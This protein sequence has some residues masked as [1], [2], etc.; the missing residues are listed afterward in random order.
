MPLVL[1]NAVLCDIDPPRVE[2][3]NLRIDG[4]KIVARGNVK[5]SAGDEVIDCGG[6]VLLPGLVNGHTHLYSA[7]AVGMPAPPRAPKNFLEILQ[8]VWWRLDRALDAEGIETSALIGALEAVRCGT[9]TLIDHHASPNCIDGSL[10]LIE[11]GLEKVGL[12]GVLCYEVTDRNGKSGREA[13]LEEDRRYIAKCLKSRNGRFAALSGAHASFT[14]DDLSLIGIHQWADEF[15][16]GVHI[17]VAEDPCDDQISRQRYKKPLMERLSLH[18]LLGPNSVLAHCIHLT[19]DD[20]DQ[21]NEV[22]PTIAHNPRSN[23]NN[24]VGYAPLSKLKCPIMLGTD[25]IGA[26]MFTEART[27]WFKSCEARQ[28]LS[29]GD[30][31]RMLAASARRASTSLGV[32]LGQL[33]VGAAADV[34]ITDYVPF[35]PLASENLAAHVIFALGSQHVRHVMV[36]GG[37]VLRDRVVV[38]C[39]EAAARRRAIPVAARLWDRMAAIP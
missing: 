26:D 18:Q 14:L 33:C 23:M 31:L 17:H 8:L 16:V 1:Q 4:G 28:G 6:A 10:D 39:D 20:I 29:P 9:T 3:G 7:L 5:P 36:E 2:A 34:V 13:G 37:W 35:T 38:C 19:D 11:R 15:G 25:G 12:R 21:L 30:I 27:A 24:A 22:Q 32:T